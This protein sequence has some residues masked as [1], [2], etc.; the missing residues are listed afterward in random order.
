MLCGRDVSRRGQGSRTFETT[1][2][3]VV[4][5]ISRVVYTQ[6]VELSP[7]NPNGLNSSIGMVL[8]PTTLKR[9]M[10]CSN[11]RQMFFTQQQS[12]RVDFPYS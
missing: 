9:F 2:H 1:S 12:G 4:S 11:L 6:F 5:H 10:G 7:T 8:C 3:V